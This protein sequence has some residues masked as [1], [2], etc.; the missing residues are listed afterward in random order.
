MMGFHKFFKNIKFL[1]KKKLEDIIDDYLSDPTT[2]FMDNLKYELKDEIINL[3]IPKIYSFEESVDIVVNSN[4]SICRFGDGELELMQGHNIPLQKASEK[5]STRL[6]EVLSSNKDN[7]I[8]GIPWSCYNSK[9]QLTDINKNFWRRKGT[10]FRKVMEKYINYD[11]QYCAAEMT[12]IYSYLKNYDYNV[13][14]NKIRKIWNH[15]NIAIICGDGIFN[16]L[17]YNIFDNAKSVEYQYAPAI[18]AFEE[19]DNILKNALKINKDKI[20]IIILGPTAK[21]LA[22]DMAVNGYRALD[23]GHIAKSYDW[24]KKQKRTDVMEDA[25][26]F[27]N[28]D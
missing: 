17:N 20:V 15:K 22:Y 2:N 19:Y 18:N 3:L 7:I 25:I 4:L 5:L 23:L 16:K 10:A 26:E 11:Q 21:I 28:P 6:K 1:Y 13:Y 27:F 9:G 24:Y 8:I 14:F 12:L